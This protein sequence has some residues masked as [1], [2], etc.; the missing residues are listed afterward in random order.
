MCRQSRETR[1]RL[2]FKSRDNRAVH[3]AEVRSSYSNNFFPLCSLSQAPLQHLSAQWGVYTEVRTLNTSTLPTAEHQQA[4]KLSACPSLRRS[5]S[6]S[7]CLFWHVPSSPTLLPFVCA[8]S[9][10][11]TERQSV[12]EP[13]KYLKSQTNLG[14]STSWEWISWQTGWLTLHRIL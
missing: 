5:L 2:I 11:Q 10:R 4:L 14:N 1:A 12:K 9:G 13:P 6:H 3:C 7:S 8:D